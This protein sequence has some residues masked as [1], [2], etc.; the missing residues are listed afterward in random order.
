M[1]KKKKISIALI[2]SA[3]AALLGIVAIIMLAAPGITYTLEVLGKKST[4][5]YSMAQLTFGNEKVK[6]AFSFMN[7]LPF[8]LVVAGI[9]LA[10]LTALKGNKLTAIIAAVC[11]LAAGVLFFCCKQ[12]IVFDTGDLSGEAKDAA[13]KLAKEAYKE[14]KLGIGAIL[15]G[16]LSILSAISCA[17]AAVLGKK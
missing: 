10:A 7:F 16:I 1:A 3:V 17:G 5:N 15:A 11:F 6:F 4:T 12:L 13:V 2:L 9:V 8:L 14:F